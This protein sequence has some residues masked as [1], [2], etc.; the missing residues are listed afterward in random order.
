VIMTNI[1]VFGLGSM[2]FGMAMSLLRADHRV[3]G[4]DVNEAAGLRFQGE[5]G[6]KTTLFDAAALLDIAVIAV[7][8][9]A[10]TES[11]LLAM[12]DLRN[13]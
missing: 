10:Q 12:T 7:V 3:F 6:E 5:G 9:A 1:G 2:G 11:V 4:F 13:D 8:N